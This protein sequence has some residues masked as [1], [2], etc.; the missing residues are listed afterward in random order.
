VVVWRAFKAHSALGRFLNLSAFG[1][2]LLCCLQG[3]SYHTT[4]SAGTNL[5]ESVNFMPHLTATQ[6]A[7]AEAAADVL[8]EQLQALFSTQHTDQGCKA[9][10]AA[11]FL[12]LV[13]LLLLLLLLHGSG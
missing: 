11:K 6:Q 8:S 10:N 7:A 13:L 3:I 5:A 1:F 4:L 2:V 9:L 12:Y